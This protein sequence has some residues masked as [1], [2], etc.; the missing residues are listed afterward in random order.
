[1]LAGPNLLPFSKQTFLFSAHNFSDDLS[2]VPA[3]ATR[4]A[5]A[6]HFHPEGIAGAIAVAV[7]SAMAS[8]HQRHSSI[9]AAN[10]IWDAVLDFTPDSKVRT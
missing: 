3:M 7:G 1:V 9:D 10:A 5:Q 8:R 6:T 4:S 2:I